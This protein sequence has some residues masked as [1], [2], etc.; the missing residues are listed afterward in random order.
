MDSTR[1]LGASKRKGTAKPNCAIDG[2]IRLQITK[3]ASE[4]DFHSEPMGNTADPPWFSNTQKI[5]RQWVRSSGIAASILLIWLMWLLPITAGAESSN[6][7]PPGTVITGTNWQ[8]YK[9]YMTDGMQALFAGTSF[10]KFPPDFQVVVGPTHHYPRPPL[11]LKETAQYASQVKIVD[12]PDGRHTIRNYVAGLP[13]PDPKEPLKGWKL[14]V[15]DWYTYA[16]HILCNDA[17]GFTFVDRFGNISRDQWWFVQRIQSHIADPGYPTV[18]TPGTFMTANFYIV[19]PEEAKY[20]TLLDVYYEP[21]ERTE[22]SFLFIPALRRSL[23]LS[24]G[25]RCSPAL[26]SDFTID[27]TRYGAFNGNPSRFDAKF[28]GDRSVL[29]MPDPDNHLSGDDAHFYQPLFFPKPEV[30]KWE[31]RDSWVINAKRV[32]SERAGYC[33]GSRVLYVDKEAYSAIWAELYD[34]QGKLWKIDYDP[35]GQVSVPGVGREWSNTGWGVMMDVQNAHLTRVHLSG[36]GRGRQANS[37]CRNLDG[38]DFT[39]LD[40]WSSVRGLAE[41]VR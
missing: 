35:Q 19:S 41:I 13:F 25:A 3:E 14:L 18:E 38:H 23:R 6:P 30:G 40:R 20:T 9:Q 17:C 2:E 22:N 24:V 39:N 7:V 26:G 27:D 29:E 16:P 1:T 15:D 33:Y 36:A 21:M 4:R 11:F 37:N 12:L 10:W 28:V 32:P 8:H 34:S 31:V 5:A